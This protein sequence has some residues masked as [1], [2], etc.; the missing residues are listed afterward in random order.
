MMIGAPCPVCRRAGGAVRVDM[1]GREL[2]QL[3]STECA[4]IFL[5]RP[6]NL[7]FNEKKAALAGGTAAGEYLGQ[8][9]QTDL[10][11]LT[12]G[13]WA[14]FCETLFRETCADLRRQADDEI[15]F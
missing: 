10:A 11:R 6:D 15:P 14:T 8:I 2:A 4:R 13:Q 3:C 7:D 9:G 12:E 5:M 1:P